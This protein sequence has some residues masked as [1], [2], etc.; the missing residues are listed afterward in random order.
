MKHN[1]LVVCNNLGKVSIRSLD[2]FET[3]IHSIKDAQHYCEVAKYSPD[4]THL[5][6]GSH[7]NALYIYNIDGEKYH[8]VAK[9]HRNHA[10]VNAIDWS[11]DSQQ[12]RTSSGDYEVLY[13]DVQNKEP[14]VHGNPECKD[15]ASNTVKYGDDRK[16]I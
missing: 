4:E 14:N 7:D 11:S 8:L 15:W 3:K 10:W 13:F 9:D 1:H 5:A 16:G 6:I 12:I 2:N